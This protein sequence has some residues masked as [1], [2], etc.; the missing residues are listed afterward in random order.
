MRKSLCG[1][2]FTERILTFKEL[3]KLPTN[4]NCRILSLL[5]EFQA[6]S[7][8]LFPRESPLSIIQNDLHSQNAKFDPLAAIGMP[9][10]M[11]RAGQQ[12]ACRLP[13]LRRH[14]GGRR[15]SPVW[16]NEPKDK[17]LSGSILCVRGVANCFNTRVVQEPILNP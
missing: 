13:L 12:R 8:S 2:M 11:Q 1:L 7:C 3:L 14:V 16:I 10:L 15:H 5:H 17:N 9:L 6:M 4:L